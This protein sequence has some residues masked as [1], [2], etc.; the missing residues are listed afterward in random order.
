ML[1]G[2]DPKDAA[3]V[4]RTVTIVERSWHRELLSELS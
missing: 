3:L 1:R 4:A 2:V